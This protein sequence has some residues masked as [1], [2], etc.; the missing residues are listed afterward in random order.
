M[1]PFTSSYDLH[2]T[3]PVPLYHPDPRVVELDMWFR[4]IDPSNLVN[5]V[6]ELVLFSTPLLRGGYFSAS[7]TCRA[8][9]A[10]PPGGIR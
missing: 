8:I 7:I 6:L 4:T 3:N 1:K 10:L 5:S 9:W 2:Y